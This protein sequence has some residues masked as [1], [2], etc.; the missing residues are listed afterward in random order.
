MGLSSTRA[1]TPWMISAMKMTPCR[2]M[3]SAMYLMDP[4][5]K[6]SRQARVRGVRVLARACTRASTVGKQAALF[7]LAPRA[8]Q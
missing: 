8:S 1:T 2:E 5:Q 3:A 6:A 7:A 4:F